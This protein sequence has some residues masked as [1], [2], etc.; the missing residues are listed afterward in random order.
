MKGSR[1]VINL[2]NCLLAVGCFR[3]HVEKLRTLEDW[4]LFPRV[5]ENILGQ[6]ARHEKIGWLFLVEFMGAVKM[7]Y[8]VG[9]FGGL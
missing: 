6:N 2:R 5:C 1:K 8:L 9:C 7:P 3:L 4:L